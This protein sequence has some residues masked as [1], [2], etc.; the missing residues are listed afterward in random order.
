MPA[1]EIAPRAVQL[2]DAP[3][4]G[5]PIHHAGA[6]EIRPRP[7]EAATNADDADGLSD[8]LPLVA[9]DA[10]AIGEMQPVVLGAQVDQ[11]DLLAVARPRAGCR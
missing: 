8:V 7:A 11:R 3:S 5:D 4:A 6:D 9:A 10:H 1:Q 2:G